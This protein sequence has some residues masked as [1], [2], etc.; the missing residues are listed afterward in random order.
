MITD[1]NLVLNGLKL[2]LDST[3]DFTDSVYI[4][5]EE[6]ER[7]LLIENEI[8]EKTL[9][10]L[11]EE[12]QFQNERLSKQQQHQSNDPNDLNNNNNTNTN[13]NNNSH[14]NSPNLLLA[15]S[16]SSSIRFF[17]SNL[18]TPILNECETLKK[19]L[20]TQTMQLA[21]NLFRENQDARLLNCIKTYSL[22]NHYDLLIETLDKF[23]EYSDHVLEIC[24]LLRHISTLDV[25]EVT[26]EHHYNVFDNLAKMIQSSSGT[27]ALYPTCKSAV[28]NLSLF[29]T[30]WENQINDLSVL[31]KEMQEF[32]QG[33]RSNKS[34]YL[35]LP[36]P[37]VCV[38]SYSFLIYF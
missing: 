5:N 19:Q 31:V 15:S 13:N 18:C 17:F 12:Q 1:P 3:Q 21:N 20:Q 4:K 8:K 28:E 2:L 26:C 32:M 24:K 38:F 27:A 25:F 23:K 35:S 30:S 6:R 37:G 29:C 22:S 10:Y 36:R 7:M 14:N 9:S 11:R 33:N 16:S 34:V